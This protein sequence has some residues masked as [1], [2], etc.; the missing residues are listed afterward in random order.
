ME[1]LAFLIVF[2]IL[3][4]A[5]VLLGLAL[6]RHLRVRETVYDW[7]R[8]LLVVDGRVERALPPGRH[9]VSPKDAIFG[10]HRTILRL[11]AGEQEAT[12]AAQEVMT[13]D[14]LQV[15]AVAVVVYTVE[16]DRAALGAAAPDGA[17][18]NAYAVGAALQAAVYRE[19]QLAIRTLVGERTLD[20]VLAER[21]ALDAALAEAMAEAL[22]RYGLAPVRAAL[23]DVILGAKLRRAYEAGELARLEAEAALERARGET[24]ALRSL[25][26]AARMT[27]DNPALLSLRLV[28]TLERE[29]AAGLTL[30]LGA[31]G[32]PAGKTAGEATGG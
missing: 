7:E 23:R 21:A 19:A 16:D 8:A 31:D 9:A 27:K 13:A 1:T 20:A 18:I 5:A 30:V 24:A 14:R 4:M 29:G 17:R 3:A 32:L 11:P 26:N 25:A 2:A 12:T 6:G 28:Q 15:K 10:Q 22:P